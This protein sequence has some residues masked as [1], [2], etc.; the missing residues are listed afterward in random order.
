MVDAPVGH[1]ALG[2]PSLVRV[3][4][5]F[6]GG[7]GIGEMRQT[8]G[9]PRVVFENGRNV[10]QGD[11]VVLFCSERE[12]RRE[13]QKGGTRREGCGE[14]DREERPLLASSFLFSLATRPLTLPSDR[15]CY[16]PQNHT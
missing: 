14:A 8:L 10:D 3:G 4:E 6:H 13:V 5:C 16:S 15:P 2:L 7:V 12:P 9:E 11:T 1:Y